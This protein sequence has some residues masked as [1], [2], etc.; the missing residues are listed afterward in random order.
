M[1]IPR[2]MREAAERTIRDVDA[3]E[4]L[5]AETSRIDHRRKVDGCVRRIFEDDCHSC[6]L[7]GCK[8]ANGGDRNVR[9]AAKGAAG[10]GYR[11]SGGQGIHYNL[12]WTCDGG[13]AHVLDGYRRTVSLGRTAVSQPGRSHR[14]LTVPEKD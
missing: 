14:N 2:K 8:A 6:R 5:L 4:W 11:Y 9:P 1:R 12:Y 3:F 13:G 7:A 10:V